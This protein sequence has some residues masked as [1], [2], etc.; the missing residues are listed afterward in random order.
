MTDSE[1]AKI[2]ES[3][4]A[5]MAKVNANRGLFRRSDKGKCCEGVRV[6]DH[7]HGQYRRCQHEA[8]GRGLDGL[9]YCTRH[10]KQHQ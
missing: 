5:S 10:L 7:G 3:I 4:A 2:K 1:A 6:K 8:T 9:A